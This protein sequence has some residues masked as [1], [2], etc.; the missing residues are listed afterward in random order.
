MR[1]P[2]WQGSP[3][4]EIRAGGK[5]TREAGLLQQGKRA[6][7]EHALLAKDPRS[8]ALAKP[9]HLKEEGADPKNL[10]SNGAG[11]VVGEQAIHPA[12]E[13]N[14]HD[15]GQTAPRERS[16]RQSRELSDEGE[17]G[18]HGEKGR[19]LEGSGSER[20]RLAGVSQVALDRSTGPAP[21]LRAS[22]R[23]GTPFSQVPA[24]QLLE[25]PGRRCAGPG[26][27][28]SCMTVRINGP[29][30]AILRGLLVAVVGVAPVA[31][32]LSYAPP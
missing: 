26:D 32:D 17:R 11:Q 2:S 21:F 29:R 7:L 16:K 30:E 1:P 19:D 23:H 3:G 6:G 10:S 14:D 28:A 27:A 22:C 9:A 4:H 25:V 12:A 13:R 24:Q 8:F 15:P 31:G 18:D 5:L 20:S